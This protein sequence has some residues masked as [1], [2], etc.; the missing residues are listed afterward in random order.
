[1]NFDICRHILILLKQSHSCFIGVTIFVSY[2]VLTLQVIICTFFYYYHLFGNLQVF[3]R[4][5]FCK[6][7]KKE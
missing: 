4:K 2:P 7:F 1:M 5:I 6:A 3:E